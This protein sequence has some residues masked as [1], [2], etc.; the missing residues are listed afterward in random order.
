[1]PRPV[2]SGSISFGLINIPVKMF[3][4]T[5]SK[6]LHFHLLHKK[7]HTRLRQKM[8]CPADKQEVQRADAVKGFE[9]SPDRMVVLDPKEV[10]SLMPK[11]SR[12]L[13]VMDFVELSSI[14]SIYFD[15][16]YY[17]LPDERAI[18]AYHLFCEAMKRTGKVAVAHFVM[19]NKQYLA[20][21]RPLGQWLC[22]ETMFY[23]DE[24]VTPDKLEDLPKAPA[25]NEK[26]LKMAEKLIGSLTIPWKPKK[27]HDEYRDAVMAL[28]EKKSRGKHIVVQQQAP[29]KGPK[30]M[31]LMSALEASLQE[32]GK[33][34]RAA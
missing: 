28:I 20:A 3:S 14:D 22:L 10:E 29:S 16:P 7:D 8:V 4:A 30:V 13:E 34:R 15:Q 2:W 11:S 12:A 24:I 18:K 1:M 25:L 17:L 5:R 23:A 31:D 6:D 26:E 27:Y 9:V 33:K 19:R 32:T 21:L